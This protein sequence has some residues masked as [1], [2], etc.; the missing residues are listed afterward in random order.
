MV[1]SAINCNY[2]K[3]SYLEPIV[4]FDFKSKVFPYLK[5]AGFSTV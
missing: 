4:Y 3:H 2:E 1:L 5:T